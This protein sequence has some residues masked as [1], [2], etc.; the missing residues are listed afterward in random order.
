MCALEARFS[1]V[2]GSRRLPRALLQTRPVTSG[3][4]LVLPEILGAGGAWT[5][6]S[7]PDCLEGPPLLAFHPSPPGSGF[8][9]GPRVA[10]APPAHPH[11]SGGREFPCGRCTRTLGCASR[12]LGRRPDP[13]LPCARVYADN[14]QP[15]TGSPYGT[16]CP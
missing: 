4:G 10:S 3:P 14:H 11:F 5:I 1:C 8:M 7:T 2:C 13:I 15:L 9:A 16:G 12:Q 6:T